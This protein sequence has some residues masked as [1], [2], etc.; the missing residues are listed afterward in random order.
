MSSQ[1]F[2]SSNL[3]QSWY[4]FL[5]AAS[6]LSGHEVIA[7]G[8]T[9]PLGIWTGDRECTWSNTCTAPSFPSL[10]NSNLQPNIPC[11]IVRV[12][13]PR[14]AQAR[15][16]S[17]GQPPRRKFA[18]ILSDVADSDGM[19]DTGLSTLRTDIT[20]PKPHNSFS[21]TVQDNICTQPI[22]DCSFSQAHR[23]LLD[24]PRLIDAFDLAFSQ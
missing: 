18:L 22:H 9:A 20:V 7:V 4:S 10:G 13:S 8:R 6:L 1:D 11:S 3:N 24:W 5:K 14:V 16:D 21:T 15:A 17:V 12:S 23:P 19:L 2:T